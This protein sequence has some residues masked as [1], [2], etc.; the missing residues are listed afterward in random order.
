MKVN[1]THPSFIA[2]LESISTNILTTIKIEDYF[3]LTPEKKLNFSFTVLNLIKSSARVKANLS[4]DDLKS[5]ITV[6]CKKNEE[7]ENY[8]FAAVLRDV[9][10]NFD[11]LTELSNSTK[12]PTRQ[13]KKSNKDINPQ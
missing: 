7:T 11:R 10:N 1:T 8:E 3:G 2:F 9:V 12:K 5:F 13:V 6:L 4:D